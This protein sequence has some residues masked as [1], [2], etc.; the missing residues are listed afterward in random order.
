MESK[1]ATRKAQNKQIKRKPKQTYKFG[2]SIDMG[3]IQAHPAAHSMK[4]V[5][6]GASP[7]A[8]APRVRLHCPQLHSSLACSR[9]CM[10]ACLVS[11]RWF[12]KI[13]MPN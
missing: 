12:P 2:P 6:R 7:G 10:A 8:A 13:H 1:C 4:T 11:S 5:V 9:G 3:M